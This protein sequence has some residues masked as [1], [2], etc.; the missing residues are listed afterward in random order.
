MGSFGYLLNDQCDH[1]WCH[2]SPAIGT[3]TLTN[4]RIWIFLV[5]IHFSGM[6]ISAI[7][8]FQLEVFNILF[9]TTEDKKHVV[10]CQ[11]CARKHSPTLDGFTILQQYTH[12]ELMRIYDNFLHAQVRRR[13]ILSMPET[14]PPSPPKKKNRKK[15]II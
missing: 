10:H 8:L 11:D 15:L 14:N 4:D 2:L 6:N 7:S 3:N 1:P 12:E 13:H 5:C 9:V